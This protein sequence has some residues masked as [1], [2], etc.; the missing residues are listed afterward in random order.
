MVPINNNNEITDL[1]IDS[2]SCSN[3]TGI[4]NVVINNEYTKINITKIS[5]I[6]DTTGFIYSIVKLKTNNKTIIYNKETKVIKTSEHD[7]KSIQESIN[8]INNN[9]NIKF[10][11]LMGMTGESQQPCTHCVSR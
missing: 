3:K 4:E 8:N 11:N 1:I 5:A 7:C 10:K 6:T 2:T 9:I